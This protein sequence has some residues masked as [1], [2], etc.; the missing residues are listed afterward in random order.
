MSGTMITPLIE[1]T[2]QMCTTKTGI[3]K[4][5]SNHFELNVF[6]NPNNGIFNININYNF[7]SGEIH[8]FNNF[9]QKIH[10]QKIFHGNNKVIFNELNSGIYNYIIFQDHK[11][12]YSSKLLVY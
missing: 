10:E 8:F 9:G 12:I 1:F 7:E 5:I 2:K 11:P 6:P 4:Q 3:E